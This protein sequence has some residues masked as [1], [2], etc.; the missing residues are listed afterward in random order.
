MEDNTLEK[1]VNSTKDKAYKYLKDTNEYAT[2]CVMPIHLFEI[3]VAKDTF[4]NYYI[5][6]YRIEDL[7]SKFLGL[8]IIVSYD[9]DIMVGRLI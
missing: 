4:N 6:D 3:L 5:P 1:I 2:H 7:K 8:N 9:T